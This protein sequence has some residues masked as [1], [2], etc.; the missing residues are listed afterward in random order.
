MYGNYTDH[1]CYDCDPSCISCAFNPSYCYEC[2]KSLGFAWND[3]TCYSPCPDGTFLDNNDTNCSDCHPFCQLC[4]INST[5]CSECTL[6]GTWKAYLLN[7]ECLLTCP[8]EYYEET[9][10]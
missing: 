6:N 9:N 7:N 10:N 3:Y 5:Y 1:V 4:E 2:D 8:V